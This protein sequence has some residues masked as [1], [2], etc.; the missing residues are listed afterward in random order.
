[1]LRSNFRVASGAEIGAA[2]ARGAVCGR[3]GK[4]RET[5][6]IHERLK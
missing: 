2:G 5:G 4:E 3:E 1:M 6:R